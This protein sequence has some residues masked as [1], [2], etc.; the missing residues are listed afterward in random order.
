MAGA[1]ASSAT[2]S[3]KARPKAF[4]TLSQRRAAAAARSAAASSA[5]PTPSDPPLRME[6][7]HAARFLPAGTLPQIKKHL[8][9]AF[10]RILPAFDAAVNSSEGAIGSKGLKTWSLLGID[11]DFR[12][13]DAARVSLVPLVLEANVRCPS[14]SLLWV[15]RLFLWSCVEEHTGQPRRGRAQPALGSAC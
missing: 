4:T 9:E 15:Q 10:L 7:Q 13:D 1:P 5:V 14:C 6:L 2:S 3:D 12:V 8:F 11:T